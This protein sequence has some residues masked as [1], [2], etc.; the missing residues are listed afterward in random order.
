MWKSNTMAISCAW[1]SSICVSSWKKI[2]LGNHPS[3]SHE[4]CGFWRVS[5]WQGVCHPLTVVIDLGPGIWPKL[6]QWG[7]GFS[8]KPLGNTCFLFFTWSLKKFFLGVVLHSMW[9]HSSLTRDQICAPLHWKYG[10][11]TTGQPGKSYMLY[12]WCDWARRMQV[13]SVW[14]PQHMEA[15]EYRGEQSWEMKKHEWPTTDIFWA[16]G[17][18][19]PGKMDFHPP[20]I[21]VG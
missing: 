18:R 9:N 3:T 10:V 5:R 7:S 8:W 17:S 14:R 4:P 21:W 13:W 15:Y 1:L 16:L 12:F 6:V 11:L 20:D 19:E 2:P